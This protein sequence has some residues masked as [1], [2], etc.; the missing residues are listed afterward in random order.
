MK[1]RIV[2]V[3]VVLA[4][5]LGMATALSMRQHKS[6]DIALLK[7]FASAYSVIPAESTSGVRECYAGETAKECPS[8][9]YTVSEQTCIEAIAALGAK[10]VDST[11]D[12]C[13]PGYATKTYQG[14]EVQV[15]VG[16]G[17][18]QSSY[19]IQTWLEPRQ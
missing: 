13:G 10:L 4:V 14:R 18:Q 17:N 12:K 9:T 6:S 3:L 5:A 1:K 16:A 19:W 7:S 2:V 15:Y 8:I 11:K